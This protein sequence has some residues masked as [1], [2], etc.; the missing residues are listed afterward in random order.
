MRK[1]SASFA[2]IARITACTGK[3]V[4]NIR[5]KFNRQRVLHTKHIVD[6]ERGKGKLNIKIVRITFKSSLRNLF[7]ATMKEGPNIR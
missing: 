1:V 3:L 2:D 4:K 6:L 7:C 5:T